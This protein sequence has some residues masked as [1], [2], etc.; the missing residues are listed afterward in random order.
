MKKR[1]GVGYGKVGEIG[2]ESLI[3]EE[4][5]VYLGSSRMVNR[6]RKEWKFAIIAIMGF[7]S[8]QTIYFLERNQII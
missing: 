3:R 8:D 2:M 5:I 6:F 1:M 7:V 4:P